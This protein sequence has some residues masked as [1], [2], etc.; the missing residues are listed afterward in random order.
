MIPRHLIW[1]IKDFQWLQLSVFDFIQHSKLIPVREIEELVL[2]TLHNHDRPVKK[3]VEQKHPKFDPEIPGIGLI[4]SNHDKVI[5]L[6]PYQTL[7]LALWN[8]HD[9]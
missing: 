7:H 6:H 9:N 2:V 4:R 1:I 8:A 5:K 3:F